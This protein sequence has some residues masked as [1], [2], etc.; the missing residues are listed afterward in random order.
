MCNACKQKIPGFLYILCRYFTQH[1]AR[2]RFYT[3]RPSGPMSGNSWTVRSQNWGP[4]RSWKMVRQLLF[5][6]DVFCSST[7]DCLGFKPYSLM[8]DEQSNSLLISSR[9]SEIGTYPASTKHSIYHINEL[10]YD[11]PCWSFENCNP[12]IPL[13]KTH[14]YRDD[15][16][17]VVCFS[18]DK[19]K[20]VT[21]HCSNPGN[22]WD[23][24]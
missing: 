10:D 17:I 8:Y 3:R 20:K 15:D 18:D 9:R 1:Q 19:D 6:K 16:D 2:R 22:R 14:L 24:L 5:E 13:A 21:V 7:D 12:Q 4:C 23:W 11:R